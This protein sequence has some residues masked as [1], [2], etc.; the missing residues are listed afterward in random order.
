[1]KIW[2]ANGFNQLTQQTVGGEM[3]LRGNV[4]PKSM[5]MINNCKLPRQADRMEVE[6]EG[7]GCLVVG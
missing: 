6:E 5:V 2:V 7:I 1:M 4:S 3:E